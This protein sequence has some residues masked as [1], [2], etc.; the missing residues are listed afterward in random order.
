M[1]RVTDRQTE[2]SDERS[3]AGGMRNEISHNDFSS[4]IFFCSSL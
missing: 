3:A 4:T 1:E 2:M